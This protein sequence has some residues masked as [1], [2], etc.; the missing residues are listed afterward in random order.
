VKTKDFF[1][2]YNPVAGRGLARR[3]VRAVQAWLEERGA[4][5]RVE[6]TQ[7][8]GK[9]LHVAME[10]ARD[11]WPVVVAVGG[12]GTINEVVNGLLH[13]ED[14]GIPCPV[15]GIVPAG[16]GNDFVKVLGLYRQPFENVMKVLWQAEQ[17]LV[18]VGYANE[19]YFLNGLGWGFDGFVAQEVYRVRWLRGFAAYLWAVLK[20]LPSYPTARLHM[21]LDERPPVERDITMVAVTN[22]PC[23]G[24]GFWICPHARVDDG[25][26]DIAMAD[27]MR[28]WQLLPLL[29]RVMH[30]TH[31]NHPR[32]AFDKARRVVLQSERPLPSQVDGELLG[33]SLQELRIRIFPQRLAV[34]S[35]PFQ[36]STETERM[37]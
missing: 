25:W 7:A 10:A 27:A 5:L 14:E 4:T 37:Q 18:D 26:L 6:A 28:P 22:G 12:D 35:K 33:T 20:V 24:G 8:H 3:R 31:V 29:P 1:I 36:Q 2:V 17:R 34:L 15:L 21:V 30:G 13:A 11:G 32:V 9:G 23:Y 19:R 16:S